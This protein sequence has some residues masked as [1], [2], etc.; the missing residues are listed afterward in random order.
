MLFADLEIFWKNIQLVPE[1]VKDSDDVNISPPVMQLTDL[2]VKRHT[3]EHG[4]SDILSMNKSIV[5]IM[6]IHH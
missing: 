2:E 5:M 1:D 4:R 3:K 6:T